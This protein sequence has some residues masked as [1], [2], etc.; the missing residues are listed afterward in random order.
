MPSMDDYFKK[1]L[2]E[3]KKNGLLRQL[4]NYDDLIDF[5]SNDYLGLAKQQQTGSSGS[6]LIS[7]NSKQL[8][9]LEK[10]FASILNAEAALYYG[11]GYLANIGLIPTISDRFTTILSD[12]LIHASLI[13]GIRLSHAKKYSFK[14]NDFDHLEKLINSYDGKKIIIVETVYSMDGDSPE[15]DQLFDLVSKYE[16]TYV[17]LDE[18]HG[19][20]L[21]GDNNLGMAQSMINHPR[22]IAVVYPLGKSAGL[23][24]AFI[25]GSEILR[26][27]LINFSRPFIYSTGPSGSLI[28]QLQTQL[29]MIYNKDLSNLYDLKH[30]FLSKVNQSYHTI[31]GKYGAIVSIIT[32]EKSKFLETELMNRGFFVKAIVSPTVSKGQERL[33]ICFHD[34]NSKHQV[35]QI[36][37]ILNQSI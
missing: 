26:D 8:E 20:G 31:S 11:A 19:L 7:G 23:S 30:H 36:L 22:C 16:N 1:K 12:E 13:D 2:D 3:R 21:S 34:Y 9:K 5:S 4:S 35:D 33:R 24:G 15:L 14:H 25:V 18:A 10:E 32:Q 6:R 28:K 37:A 27:F 29:S 17:I